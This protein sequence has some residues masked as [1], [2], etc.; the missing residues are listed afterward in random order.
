MQLED[1]AMKAAR[2]HAARH[3][4]TLGQAV[5]DLDRKA[6]D[7]PLTTQERSGL[8]VVRLGAGSPRVTAADVDRLRDELP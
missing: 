7:R 2:V 6:V 1:D 8:R 4:L 5:S 3:R